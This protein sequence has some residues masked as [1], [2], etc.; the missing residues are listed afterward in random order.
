M[1]LLELYDIVITCDAEV[2]PLYIPGEFYDYKGESNN[3]KTLPEKK[4][5]VLV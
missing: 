5:N 2:D 3:Q 4:R 1:V